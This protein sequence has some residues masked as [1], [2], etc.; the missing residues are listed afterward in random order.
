MMV[1]QHP[2]LDYRHDLCIFLYLRV[3]GS[4]SLRKPFRSSTRQKRKLVL[5]SLAAGLF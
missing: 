1:S 3:S 2:E 5:S 4:S